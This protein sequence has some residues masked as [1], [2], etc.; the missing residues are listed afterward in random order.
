MRVLQLIDSLNPGGA[1]RLA[2]TLA[3]SWY[4]YHG[5]SYLCATRRDGLLKDALNPKVKYILL[6]KGS[7]IDLKALLKLRK[8]LRENEI[9]VIHAH[10]TS[11]FIATQIKMMMPKLKLIWHEH[12][13]ARSEQSTSKHKVLLRCSRFFDQIITVN[14]SLESWWKSHHSPD[15][16]CYL[17]NFVEN[18]A[19][20]KSIDDREPEIVYTANLR[21]PKNHQLLVRAF[22]Q[23]ASS[24]PDW[25][26]RLIGA[27]Y[28]DDYY[29][30]LK[31]LIEK[32]QLEER[33]ILAGQLKNVFHDLNEASIGVIASTSEGLPMSLLEYGM[34]GLA[35]V[36]TDVG[37]CSKVIS[38]FGTIVPSDEVTALSDA[39]EKYIVDEKSRCR[40]AKQFR[41]HIQS[42]YSEEAIMPEL[43]KMYL[44]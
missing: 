23:L 39:I 40:A 38:T 44:S 35:V 34:A 6:N 16:V 17:P 30:S 13:G 32:H 4:K 36:S 26:L 11:F 41:K 3:N 10:G 9:T 20:I 29:G 15:K 33:V 5:E 27:H 31:S 19:L 18:V 1:E 22:A 12:H 14:H 28:D 42:K 21:A 7:A 8:Y 43:E 25:R 24:Y 37:H 2:V